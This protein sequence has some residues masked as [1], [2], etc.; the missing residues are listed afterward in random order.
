MKNLG[1]WLADG[2]A[3]F[4]GSW[5]FIILQSVVLFMWVLIN[6]LRIVSFDPYPFILMN[7]FL[8][9]EAAYATP[10]LLMSAS[11]QGEKDR[12]QV[13]K[14]LQLDSDTNIMMKDMTT[15]LNKINQDIQ[16]DRDALK[17]HT[18]L[19]EEIKKLQEEIKNLN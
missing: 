12:A 16:L 4:I 3:N 14:D 19:Q 13:D 10:L 17:D 18:L 2:I 5:K 1:Y 9:F 7:L 6:V 11:R 15:L 8:S